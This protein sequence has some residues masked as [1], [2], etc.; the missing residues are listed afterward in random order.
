MYGNLNRTIY[1]CL[2]VKVDNINN[3]SFKAL[4]IIS[5]VRGHVNLSITLRTYLYINMSMDYDVPILLS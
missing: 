3:V 1:V 2:I 4:L 5:C